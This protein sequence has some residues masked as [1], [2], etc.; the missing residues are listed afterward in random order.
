M[1]NAIALD[2]FTFEGKKLVRMAR[3]ELA[4]REPHAPQACV[5][6]NSTTSANMLEEYSLTIHDILLWYW[7]FLIYHIFKHIALP[8]TEPTATP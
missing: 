2:R 1:G 7:Q 3:L 6:T 4:R 5:S 8:S